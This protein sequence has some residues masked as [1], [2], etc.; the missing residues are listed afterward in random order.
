MRKAP[1]P[2]LGLA[3]LRVVIG[4]IFVTHGA[5]KLFAGGVEGT[6]AFLGQV[7]IPLAAVVAWGAAILE[8]FG[9]ISLIAGFLVAPLALLFGVEMLAGIV[10]VHAPNGWYVVGPGQGGVEFNV[11]LIAGLLALLLAGPG[12]AALD[13]R[14]GPR[15]EPAHPDR[16][17]AG[18]GSGSPDAR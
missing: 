15:A 5:P 4:V 6:A 13:E 3:I 10:L 1:N 2:D 7:G 17:T 14:R 12:A 9:G 18:E 16:P 11:L 8:F